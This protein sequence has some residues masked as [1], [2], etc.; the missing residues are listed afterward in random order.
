[1][2]E[3]KVKVKG[4]DQTLNRKFLVYDEDINLSHDCDKLKNLVES[5]IKDFKEDV[6]DVI[7]TIK[8]VW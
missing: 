5:T 7:L 6:E 8:M 2:F 1:M 4:G 3:L